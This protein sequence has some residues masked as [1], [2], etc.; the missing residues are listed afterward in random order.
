MLHEF[1]CLINA[2]TVQVGTSKTFS[3]LLPPSRIWPEPSFQAVIGST[4]VSDV[5]YCTRRTLCLKLKVIGPLVIAQV[6]ACV[7]HLHGFF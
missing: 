2:L 7:H 3:V 1:T 6:L 5:G 4:V